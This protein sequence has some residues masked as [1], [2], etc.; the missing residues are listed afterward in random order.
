MT[1]WKYARPVGA[2]LLL[3]VLTIYIAFAN[4]Q[5]LAG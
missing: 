1:P 3:A 4:F 2:L 5:V